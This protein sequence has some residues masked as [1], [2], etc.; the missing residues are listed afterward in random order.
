MTKILIDEIMII[1]NGMPNSNG[2][3]LPIYRIN[4][5]SYSSRIGN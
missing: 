1:G 4:N 3:D 2:M 5:S